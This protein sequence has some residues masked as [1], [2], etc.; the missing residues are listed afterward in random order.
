MQ[1]IKFAT[2]LIRFYETDKVL[3]SMLAWSIKLQLLVSLKRVG[4][5]IIL[6]QL[7]SLIVPA[8]EI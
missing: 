8:R 3:G 2:G 4:F 1:E 7:L 5:L 6:I